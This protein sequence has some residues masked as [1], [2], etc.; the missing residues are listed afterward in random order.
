MTSEHLSSGFDPSR[1]SEYAHDACVALRVA[2]AQMAD[3]VV[4]AHE[5][6]SA[7][8]RLGVAEHIERAESQ[9]IGLRAIIGKQQAFVSASGLR[10]SA[11]LS[12][13]VAQT[14][15]MARAA[16][17]DPWCG[18][19]DATG[20]AD[21]KQLA[22]KIATLD[23]F[24]DHVPSPESLLAQA[25]ST[26]AVALATPGI[27]NSEGANASWSRSH[28]CLAT[29]DNFCGFYSD[30]SFGLSCSVLAGE[31]D[32]MESDYAGHSTRFAAELESPETLG[33]RAAM[34]T[35]SRLNPRKPKSARLPI[36][37]DRRV[38]ASL[39]GH[40]ASTISGSA[41]ARGT[42][43]LKDK[44]EQ[45]IMPEAITIT[46]DPHQ[47]RGHA[48]TIFDGEG[49]LCASLTL[50]DKGVLRHWLTDSATARQLDMPNNARANRSIG[51]P[52]TP[53][54]TNLTLKPGT[55]S[56][57]DLI[58]DIQN[59]FLVT[60]LIGMGVNM[61]TGD[62]S[63]GASGFWIKNGKITDPISEVTIADN[64]HNMFAN[65]TAA[66]DLEYRGAINAPSLRVDQMSLAG[67]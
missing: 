9:D 67:I 8:A 64:L 7:S 46:D 29:S 16:H 57:D 11:G 44:Y 53:G 31:G 27:V 58:G 17:D 66:D 13:L 45:P 14:I 41:I 43:F 12:E 1:L 52:P 51:S 3:V 6:I 60:E 62:Y 22:D 4:L 34:R 10:D 18:L 63:R 36:I 37:F 40:F 42:S 59:G 26:E 35:L 56:R 24:D 33:A 21:S 5:S 54:P 50:V 47:I 65:I 20:L 28:L 23:L 25:I 15:A 39:L 55:I 49:S 48:S 38:S 30:S 2:G 61:V 19:A 32:K